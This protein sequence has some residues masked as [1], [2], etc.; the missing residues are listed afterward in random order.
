MDAKTAREITRLHRIDLQ[1]QL[2]F[3]RGKERGHRL[4]MIRGTRIEKIAKA[5]LEKIVLGGAVRRYIAT[6]GGN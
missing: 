1:A 3:M 6:S 2:H 4:W 5:R